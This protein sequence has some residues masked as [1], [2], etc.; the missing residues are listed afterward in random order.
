MISA[1]SSAASFT[2][3]LTASLPKTSFTLSI[4][5]SVGS[6]IS[7][8]PVFMLDGHE[9]AAMLGIADLMK[10]DFRFRQLITDALNLL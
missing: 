3:S 8:A 5:R 2:D 1:V 6:H 9:D 7:L 10:K 4:T